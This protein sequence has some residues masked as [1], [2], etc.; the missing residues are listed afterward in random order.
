MPASFTAISQHLFIHRGRVNVS[1]LHRGEEAL[2]LDVG[3]GE[4]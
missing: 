2:L 4:V 3:D 1:V